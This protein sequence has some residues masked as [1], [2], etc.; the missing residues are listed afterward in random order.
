[1]LR[2][3]KPA[4]KLPFWL[5]HNGV[6]RLARTLIRS[7]MQSAF[8]PIT[9]CCKLH[10]VDNADP[11][12]RISAPATTCLGPSPQD[13]LAA[14]EA[15]GCASIAFNPITA[16]NIGKALSRIAAAEGLVLP[17]GVASGIADAAGG[18]LRNA[19]QNLQVVL[20]G[21]KPTLVQGKVRG[22]SHAS[23]RGRAG[24]TFTVCGAGWD[25]AGGCTGC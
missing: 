1:M 15:M 23:L 2:C 10:A 13:V 22:T 14:L 24:C 9:I 17:P 19:V 4:F 8:S 6:L 11:P 3:I 20:G 21:A 25:G 12:L 7:G 18:D 16:N 5:H